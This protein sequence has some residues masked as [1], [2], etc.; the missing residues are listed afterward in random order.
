MLNTYIH[1]HARGISLVRFEKR[2]HIGI[3]QRRINTRLLGKYKTKMYYVVYLIHFE[4]YIIIP[5]TWIRESEKMM[6]KFIRNG[7]NCA[8]THWCFFSDYPEAHAILSGHSV[9]NIK[10]EADFNALQSEKFPC[11]K[12]IFQC[13]VIDFFGE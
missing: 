1:I 11:N 5:Y 3:N 10:Y 12:G 6:Q 2:N 4:V 13:R 8:Q 7:V 9:P